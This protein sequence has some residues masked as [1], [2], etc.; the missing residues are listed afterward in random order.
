VEVL[1][2]QCGRD[3]TE[4]RHEL[5]GKT[6]HGL[7]QL[8]RCLPADDAR[9]GTNAVVR[10]L[11]RALVE[12][13]LPAPEHLADVLE[14]ELLYRG[15]PHWRVLMALD[16]L[17][18]RDQRPAMIFSPPAEAIAAEWLATESRHLGELAECVTGWP[19]AVA[20]GEA[21]FEAYRRS[22]PEARAKALLT[23]GVIRVAPPDA[24]TI[25]D[26][27]RDAGVGP[28]ALSGS[29]RRL[30][31]ER[32]PEEVVEAFAAAA[33]QHAS[34]VSATQAGATPEPA[35]EDAARSAAER[36]LFELLDALP[37]TAGRFTLNAKPG[38]PFGGRAAEIDLL[39]ASLA[40]AV[41]V[42]GY[43]HFTDA[44]AYR[45]DRRKDWE[46]Q[47]HGYTVLRVLAADV[48]ERMEDVLDRILA[49]VDHC[50]RPDVAARTPQGGDAR[51]DRDRHH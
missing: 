29:V 11:G 45:R 41:E 38:F 2:Q 28:D 7:D 21:D 19:L 22:A 8:L 34:V 36:F 3:P 44:D 18:A 12:G 17:L 5:A 23:G 16:D 1:A 43:H 30:A 46:L 9:A 49:A 50:G 40:L 47:R 6:L 15:R 33:I 27:L 24:G 20:V 37:R 4:L 32:A 31:A 35:R 10:R 13:A 48:V 14:A 26:R 39:A 42:D 51:S 25:A